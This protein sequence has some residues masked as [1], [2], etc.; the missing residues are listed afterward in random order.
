M[1]LLFVAIVDAALRCD[2]G[3]LFG[4]TSCRNTTVKE[5]IATMQYII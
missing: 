5:L 2:S 3:L 1:Q 4:P